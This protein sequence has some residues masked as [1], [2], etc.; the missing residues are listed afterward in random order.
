MTGIILVLALL[1]I[2][3]GPGIWAKAV[4]ARHQQDRPDYPGTGGEFASHLLELAGLESV[5]VEET[6]QGDHYDPEAKAVRLLPRHLNGR[7][8]AAVTI[9]A[10]EVGHALQD[11]HGHWAFEL[12]GPLV[13][14]TNYA[15]QFATIGMMVSPLIAAALRMPGV[16]FL[17]LV[18]MVATLVLSAVTRLVTLPVE[19]DASFGRAL[20]ILERG[21][22]IPEADLLPA[23]RLLTAAALTYVGNW[24]WSMLLL[25]RQLLPFLRY[26]R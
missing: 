15:V 1:A 8:L 5:T 17:M 20:P 16:S 18:V 19:F 12:R 6:R 9:A 22:F 11:H 10:H 3:I 26:L 7:S 24:V 2:I 23:R 4:I 13:R 14:I 21:Q 25:L